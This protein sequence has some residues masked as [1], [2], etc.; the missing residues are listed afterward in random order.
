MLESLSVQ[1]HSLHDV[2]ES[3]LTEQLESFTDCDTWCDAL[4]GTGVDREVEGRWARVIEFLNKQE[5][6]FSLDIPSGV[7]ALSGQ[8]L[9]VAVCADACATF[10]MP[11]LGQLVY[12]GRE[13]CGELYIAE[14]GLPEHVIEQVGPSGMLID[15]AWVAHA[16]KARPADY[17]KGEAGKVLVLA[18]SDEMTGAAILSAR[19]ALEGGAGLVTVGSRPAVVERIMQAVPEVMASAILGEESSDAQRRRLQQLLDQSQIVVMGPGLGQSDEVHELLSH[20]LLDP[21][22]PLVLDADALNVVASHEMHDA[23]RRGSMKRPI[24]LTPHPGERGRLVDESIEQ[25]MR[26]PIGHAR[27]LAQV[28]QCTVVLKTASTVVAA[29]DGRIAIN[30]SGNPGMATAGMGDVLTGMIAARLAEHDDPFEA[31]CLAVWLHGAAG[32]LCRDERGQRGTT[33]TGL[34]DHL[35]E[36]FTQIEERCP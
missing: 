33:A 10:G 16:L 14:I 15:R 5:R 25:V 31:V 22:Q 35:G 3:S 34:L 36:L 28:T 32:D 17:H 27:D 26:D 24:V 9:G 2:E 30:T 23:L 13:H 8:V 29:A 19:G 11:K 18:G 1:T 6:V 20:V 12:P 21:R 4:L 7:D